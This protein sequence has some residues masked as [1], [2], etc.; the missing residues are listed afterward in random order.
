MLPEVFQPRRNLM[1]SWSEFTFATA[2]SRC[3]GGRSRLRDSEIHESPER[4]PRNCLRGSRKTAS[5]A[6]KEMN[7]KGMR[8][9]AAGSGARSAISSARWR[10]GF[11][12]CGESRLSGIAA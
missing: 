1:K 10:G 12:T 3:F 7:V 9:A 4:L 6:D 2:R 8:L 5:G 11:L